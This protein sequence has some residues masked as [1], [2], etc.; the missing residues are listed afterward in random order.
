MSDEKKFRFRMFCALLST[1][2]V[3]VS[4]F[5]SITAAARDRRD[6]LTSGDQYVYDVLRAAAEEIA[7]GNRSSSIITFPVTGVEEASG[8]TASADHDPFSLSTVIYALLD[9]CPYALYWYDKT[10]TTRSDYMGDH[11]EIRMPVSA[12]YALTRQSGTCDTDRIRTSTASHAMQNAYNVAAGAYNMSIYNAL[13]YYRKWI[14]SHVSYN[15]AAPGTGYGD[16]WQLIYVFDGD[17]ATNVVCEGYSK[18]FKF[19][20][21][22]YTAK[23][24]GTELSVSLV[25]GT[26]SGGGSTGGAHMWNIV[27]MNN[28]KNYIVDLT[29]CDTGSDTSRLFLVGAGQITTDIFPAGSG[30]V[31]TIGYTVTAKDGNTF[32]YTYRRNNVNLSLTMYT[33]EEI[34]PALSDYDP[35][36]LTDT[37]R[38]V[39]D[40]SAFYYRPVYTLANAGIISGTSAD[41]FSPSENVSRGQFMMILWRAAGSHAPSGSASFTDISGSTYRDAILWAYD[42][43]IAYGKSASLFS[44]DDAMTRA[45]VVAFLERYCGGTDVQTDRFTDVLP[46]E[47]YAGAV[48]WA[49]QAGITSGTSPSTFSPDA[50][51]TRGEAASF[52]SRTAG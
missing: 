46:T 44:P 51:C 7:A 10:A 22:C 2:A 39:R 1:C 20:A 16:P 31:R 17:P 38:D 11:Y 18:A 43:G 5:P 30:T 29:N 19:L 47:Y 14:L 13:D 28:T 32:T 26:L 48:G 8:D 50:V 27:R 6:T 35:A 42:N 49:L 21:D 37:F 25:E 33:E 9:D 52:I 23:H 4:L 12:D 41:T 34:A 3:L 45:E 24:P 36:D 15:Y 40:P